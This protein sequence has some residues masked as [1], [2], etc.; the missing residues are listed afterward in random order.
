MEEEDI[1]DHPFEITAWPIVYHKSDKKS[2]ETSLCFSLF[3][4]S[5]KQITY[6]TNFSF[7]GIL[8]LERIIIHLPLIFVHLLYPSHTIQ[9][10]PSMNYQSFC[11]STRYTSRCRMLG[12]KSLSFPSYFT[13]PLS[14]P[15]YFRFYLEVL[16]F[17]TLKMRNH[18]FI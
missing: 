14:D 10:L 13:G 17:S 9:T 18:I 16:F 7:Q 6:F 3:S 12:R 11:F 5:S 4:H 8:N 2:T 1:W 15:R